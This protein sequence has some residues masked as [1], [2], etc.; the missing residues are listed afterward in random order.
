METAC[1]GVLFCVALYF[2]IRW[3]LRHYF[4]PEPAPQYDSLPPLLF[5]CWHAAKCRHVGQDLV[6]DVGQIGLGLRLNVRRQVLQ[7]LISFGL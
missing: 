5:C 1:I 6:G 4:P 3:T 2:A 7:A